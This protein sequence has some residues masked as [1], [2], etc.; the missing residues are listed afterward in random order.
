MLRD[1]TIHV[2]LQEDNKGGDLINRAAAYKAR[3]DVNQHLQHAWRTHTLM[4]DFDI[5]DV[6]RLPTVLTADQSAVLARQTLFSGME[7]L[8][9]HGLVGLL[10]KLRLVLGR[11]FKWDDQ[12]E[13]RITLRP[14]SLRER[15]AQAEGLTAAQLPPPTG[16][17]FAPVYQFDQ[18]CLDELENKTVHAALHLGRV[19]L[20]D[21]RFT[22]QL[23]VYV[24]PKGTFGR[25]YMAFIKPFRHWIVYPAIIR[26]IEQRWTQTI[27]LMAFTFIA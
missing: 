25:A 7:Q 14:G 1:S 23:A 27:L 2:A 6:W 17:D 12:P 5:E 19:P 26:M 21:T 18:E 10:F 3:I 22:V 15:Y 16:A 20:D 9:Q 4:P 8:T 11:R 24:K 13:T